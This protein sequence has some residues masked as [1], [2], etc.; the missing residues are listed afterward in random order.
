MTRHKAASSLYSQNL[1]GSGHPEQDDC[2][3]RG[4]PALRLTLQVMSSGESAAESPRRE[5]NCPPGMVVCRRT[6]V[7]PSADG[8]AAD[9]S[10]TKESVN[11]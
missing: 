7:K 4:E 2:R 8:D 10:G 9:F 6:C 1:T 3:N 11:R 5:E